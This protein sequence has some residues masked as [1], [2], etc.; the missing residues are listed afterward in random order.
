MKESRW[1]TIT[2]GAADVVEEVHDEVQ[3][4]LLVI[5]ALV[6]KFQ[7]LLLFIAALCGD[8]LVHRQ[9]TRTAHLSGNPGREIEALRRQRQSST[10]VVIVVFASAHRKDRSSSSDSF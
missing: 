6:V 10:L 7:Q 5:K 1:F 3:V 4:H 8:G 9:P 2:A